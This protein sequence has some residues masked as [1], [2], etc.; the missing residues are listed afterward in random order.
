MAA[1]CNTEQ[2]GISARLD[3]SVEW[4]FERG[5][6][7]IQVA[8]DYSADW[9]RGDLKQLR[10]AYQRLAD[11]YVDRTRAGKKFY[12]SC[13]DTRI[14]SWARGPLDRTERCFIGSRQFSIAPS[15]RL[16]PCV[17]FVQEDQD[18][19]FVIGDVFNG[20]DSTKQG[21]IACCAEQEKPECGGC[22]LLDRCSS[23]C[24]CVNWQSTGRIDQA[25]PVVCEHERLLMPIADEVA[26]R[27]WRK[28]DANF[29]HKHY[30]PAFPILSFAEQLVIEEESHVE[31]E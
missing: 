1:V 23:W 5:F 3:E 14:R 26:N 15:G 16:F 27:L 18:D 6:A 8:L 20:F 12:L 11:W 30:N 31:T 7:Y 25:S 24:A 9:T 17:Q 4:L 22:A 2:I 28:R 29:L 10:S 21:R 19:R 13:F